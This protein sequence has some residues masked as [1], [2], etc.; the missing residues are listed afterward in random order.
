MA[1]AAA[2]FFAAMNANTQNAAAR[3][4]NAQ[5]AAARNANAQNAVENAGTRGR[6]SGVSEEPT[7]ER[8]ETRGGTRGSV[9]SPRRDDAA[10][11]DA[12]KEQAPPVEAPPVEALPSTSPPPSRGWRLSAASN[13][14]RAGFS[15]FGRVARVDETS[16]PE[17]S[18]RHARAD[19]FVSARDPSPEASKSRKGVGGRQ[20]LSASVERRTSN[21]ER[22]TMRFFAENI[23]RGY[24]RLVSSRARRRT[25]VR[26][27]SGRKQWR[28]S[29]SG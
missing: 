21:V 8:R 7:S 18:M 5:N 17:V 26:S 27:S 29:S 3:N 19:V 25:R 20:I 9:R 15:G 12:P 28:P 24:V 10:E 1:A 23:T 14:S 16:E 4:A 6:D 2:A 13:R 22:R 11:D